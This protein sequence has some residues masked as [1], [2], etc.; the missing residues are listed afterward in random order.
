MHAHPPHARPARRPG[1]TLV[2]L[3]VVIGIIAILISILLPSLSRA[4]EQANRIKCMSN[5]RQIGTATFMYVNENK[6]SFPMGS[7]FDEAYEEDWIHY[8]LAGP[9][10]A[11]QRARGSP[12]TRTSKLSESAIAKYMG[13]QVSAE[14]A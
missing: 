5:L 8:Q 1:F 6:G 9:P 14:A 3:L 4:R 10:S 11:G 2:E 12:R 7:R 13:G